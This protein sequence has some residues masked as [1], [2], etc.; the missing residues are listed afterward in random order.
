MA[1]QTVETIK[2]GEYVK[3]K[4]DSVKT[5][6][7]GSYDASAKRYSLVDCDDINREVFVKRGTLLVVGFTY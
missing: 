3:R 1:Q 5:F 7:R 2:L 6:K 4:E